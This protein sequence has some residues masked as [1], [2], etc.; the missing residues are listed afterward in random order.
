M[1]LDT[2]LPPADNR[3]LDVTGFQAKIYDAIPHLALDKAC[4]HDGV[5]AEHLRLLPEIRTQVAIMCANVF[6]S[7][8][9]APM[10]SWPVFTIV[11]AMLPKPAKPGD[12]DPSAWRLI[13]LL[14]I[15]LTLLISSTYSTCAHTSPLPTLPSSWASLTAL[16]LPT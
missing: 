5:Y 7:L 8:L 4:G 10:E 3:H 2:L 11:L 15:V 16:V 14:P 1:H 9:C 6:A 13:G 12:A